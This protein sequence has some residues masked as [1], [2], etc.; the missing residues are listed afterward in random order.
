MPLKSLLHLNVLIPLLNYVS[1]ASLHAASN[2]LQPLF[3][4]MP[5][6]IGGL[7][8]PPRD[9]GYILGVYGLTN[10]LFQTFMLG[11]LVRRFGVKAVFVT[12]VAMFVPMFTFSPLMNLVVGTEGF[13][14]VVWAM[15][16]CQ[17]S[18]SL[19]ME[20]SYGTSSFPCHCTPHASVLTGAQAVC[21]CS[22]QPQRRT[23]A[24]SVRRTVLARRSSR[25]GAS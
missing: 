18:C 15:L 5:V 1:L 12:G 6:E 11:R 9:V 3:L 7:G 25:S 14:Y 23:S 21:I 19:V 13:S 2:A 8:L 4:A 16:A 17:L 24:R 10:S 22:S 20:L